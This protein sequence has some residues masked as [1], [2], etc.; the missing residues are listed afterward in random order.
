[1][2]NEE[3]RNIPNQKLNEM[4][5]RIVKDAPNHKIDSDGVV[6][7]RMDNSAPG[8]I[9]QIFVGDYCGNPALMMPIAVENN[10]SL[11]LYPDGEVIASADGERE[12][13]DHA[14]QKENY[15]RA[16]AIVFLKLR[17]VL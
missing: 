13:F 2:T 16:A 17:G 11:L 8:G 7:Y 4:V 12:D 6:L 10:I 14:E 15:C 5:T 9:D 3:I 1:M